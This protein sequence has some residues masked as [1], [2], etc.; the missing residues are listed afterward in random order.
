MT[1][2]FAKGVDSSFLRRAEV[3]P[4]KRRRAAPLSPNSRFEV[5]YISSKCERITTLVNANNSPRIKGT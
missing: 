1:Q 3:L 4:S 5:I 2:R